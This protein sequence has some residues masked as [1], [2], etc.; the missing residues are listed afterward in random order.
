MTSTGGVG[1]FFSFFSLPFI[2]FVLCC[3]VCKMSLYRCA[4]S[5]V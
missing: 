1:F 2:I 5:P 4:R 3:E